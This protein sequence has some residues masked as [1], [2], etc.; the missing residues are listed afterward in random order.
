M[1]NTVQIETAPDVLV[2]RQFTVPTVNQ[3]G[4]GI[5]LLLISFLITRFGGLFSIGS[6][7]LGIFGLALLMVAFSPESRDTARVWT[8]DRRQGVLLVG[9]QR[10]KNNAIVETIATYPLPP[11][12]SISLDD[13]SDGETGLEVFGRKYQLIVHTAKGAVQG[14]PIAGKRETLAMIVMQI[15]QFLAADS[16]AY[17]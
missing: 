15:N 16:S 1:S 5:G 10:S 2:V 17:N 14:I 7:F 9:R 6:V 13:D 12:G 11:A 8:F 4:M 3:V